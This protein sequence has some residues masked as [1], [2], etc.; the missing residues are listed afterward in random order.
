MKMLGTQTVRAL[1]LLVATAI[2]SGVAAS[3]Q[4]VKS[5][6]DQMSGWA[7]CTVC[8]GKGGKGPTAK[9]SMTQ[10][11][12]SPS[13][14]GKAARFSLSGGRSFANALWWKQL[15][16]NNSVSHFVYDLHFYMKS[17]SASQ[18]LEFDVN[19]SFGGKRWVFGTECSMSGSKT[20]RVWSAATR[21]QSTGIPCTR[22]AAY[23]WHHL[24]WEFQRANGK[25]KFISVTLDGKKSY[26]NRTYS[27]QTRSAKELNVAFQMDGN[28]SA[29]PY[30]VWVDK[31]SLKAW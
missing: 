18:A 20:W 11:I 14:D 24:T 13:I 3:A 17:P 26:V 1:T 22:P 28:G 12:N 15:G 5:N 31:I 21:W 16:A 6:I 25:V 9:Y 19:Q 8:A 4:T 2:G 23:K 27:P 10:G 30:S 7:S 29:T